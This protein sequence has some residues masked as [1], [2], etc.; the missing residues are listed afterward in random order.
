VTDP[1]YKLNAPQA[2]AYETSPGEQAILRG[3]D[4]N[5]LGAML[6]PLL[7]QQALAN[8]R[9]MQYGDQLNTSNAQQA[10][11][12]RVHLAEAAR[13]H[14]GTLGLGYVKEGLGLPE[15]LSVSGLPGLSMPQSPQT[16]QENVLRAQGIREYASRAAGTEKLGAG[17]QHM[18]EAG[19]NVD[20]GQK[21]RRPE[22]A[23]NASLTTGRPLRLRIEDLQQA[24]AN[25]RKA[26][27][28]SGDG[29]EIEYKIDPLTQIPQ[30]TKLKGV[31]GARAAEVMS[32]FNEWARTG[33]R[34]K[35]P[36]V[37]PGKAS[38]AVPAPNASVTGGRTGTA[39]DGEL[40]PEFADGRRLGQSGNMGTA[41]RGSTPAPT[42]APAQR[43]PAAPPSNGA[44]PAQV[45][46]R[47]RAHGT[48]NTRWYNGH[49][50]AIVPGKQP[51][52][53]E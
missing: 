52:L 7:N 12:S 33:F 6:G 5:N 49:W 2:A 18:A 13:Q 15:G 46:D 20:E 29:E 44:V 53:L 51:I 19:V 50:Y 27:G 36:W 39:L 26:M 10:E 40:P 11:L 23:A 9:A 41:A 14:N 34:D 30:I 43:G 1:S 16:T 48:G 32:S 4:P 47:A 25:S 24:G 8:T 3:L 17:L 35:L 37:I 45:I 31:D 28:G 21:L 38:A 22:D 42:T